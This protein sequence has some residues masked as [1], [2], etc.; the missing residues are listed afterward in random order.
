MSSTFIRRY[1]ILLAVIIIFPSIALGQTAGNASKAPDITIRD[2]NGKRI[3]L[4]TLLENGPVIIDF[5]ALWCIPCLKELPHLNK[6]YNKNKERGVTILA[7]NE[8]DPSSEAKVKPYVKG[9]RFQF[10]VAIDK[11][12]ELWRTFKIVSLP[13]LFLIDQHGDIRYSQTG[14]RPGDERLLEAEIENILSQPIQPK[15][16]EQ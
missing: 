4:K 14:Y 6:I 16:N 7:I 2:I 1:I 13:T 5:W 12:K 11:E 3:E 15:E 8:D 9:E 10:Y